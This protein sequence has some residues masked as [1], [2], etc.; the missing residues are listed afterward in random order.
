MKKMN[1]TGRKQLGFSIIEAL[2][3]LVIMGFGILSLAS[4]QVGLSHS[5]DD[6]KQRTEAVRLAQEKIEQF[7]SYTGIASTLVDPVSTSTAAL[8]WNALVD[9]KPDSPDRIT[10]NTTYER[11][12][13]FGGS[14]DDAMRGLTVKVGWINR[15]GQAQTLS[16]S[17]VVSKTDPADSGFLGF[18]LPLNTHLKR[19][20]NRN[21]DIP[22]TAV[23]MGNGQSAASFGTT[24]Q[25][26]VFDNISGDVV[27][28]CISTLTGTPTK[29]NI[30]S[31]L[32][33]SGIS[34]CND[35]TGFIVSGYVGRDPSV[36][37]T[38]WDA[39]KAGLAIDY[40]GITRNAAGTA[41]ITCQ[42]GSATNQNT[43]ETIDNYK[44]YRCVVPLSA[45]TTPPPNNGPYNWSGKIQIAGPSVWNA[46]GNKYFVCRYQF[47]ATNS[48]TD[49]N[50]R[51]VQPYVAVNKSISQQNYLIA[52]TV[53]A[54]GTTSPTC[55]SSMT[56]T[57][58]STGVL[59]Q[60]CRSASNANHA[61]ACPRAVGM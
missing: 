39:I 27:K 21:I 60:D 32:T 28:L 37:N 29:A 41:G 34:N 5:A 56:V 4:M 36:S 7:R 18:P 22:V 10:T 33:N 50:Q 31:T 53:D 40:S 46:S 51:N 25:Y 26:V 30:T 1:L 14:S 2:I 55:P 48:L 20:K 57:S 43:G 45:P 19:P 52:T 9:S 44:Y 54:T 6:A 12:W 59:H 35:I 61:T 11:T 17:S 23:D 8:N 13:T 15:A 49:V 24:G 16:L 58:V 38:D 3:A 42:V 47:T